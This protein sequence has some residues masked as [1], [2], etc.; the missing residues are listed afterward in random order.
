MAHNVSQPESDMV[1]ISVDGKEYSG[2]YT[3]DKDN[4]VQ[5]HCE[6]GM[7]QAV[8]HKLP[9]V[10]YSEGAKGLAPILMRE[11]INDYLRKQ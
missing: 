11:I 2:W 1:S 6:Y 9:N 4:W 3:I 10:S 5:V 7:K 8:L